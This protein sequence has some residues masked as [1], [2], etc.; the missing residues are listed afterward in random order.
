MEFNADSVPASLVLGGI[1]LAILESALFGVFCV[2][3]GA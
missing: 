3:L 2:I 1:L